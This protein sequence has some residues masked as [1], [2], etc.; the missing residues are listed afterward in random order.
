MAETRMSWWWA[1]RGSEPRYLL[2]LRRF[3]HTD[4]PIRPEINTEQFHLFPF[5]HRP[6]G[7]PL[8]VVVPFSP[9]SNKISISVLIS[10]LTS[11]TPLPSLEVSVPFLGKG[12]RA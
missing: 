8:P 6:G 1:C 11:F 12:M 7:G 2:T 5:L 3:L 4:S 9:R 10:F